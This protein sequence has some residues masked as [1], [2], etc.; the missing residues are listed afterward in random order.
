[1]ATGQEKGIGGRNQEFVLSASPRIAGD[2]KIV[3]GS[4][5]SDGT[6][7]PTDIAGG[8]VDGTSLES[9][10]EA[11]FNINEELRH[12]NSSP[13]L[14]AISDAV[15][16]GNTGTNLRDLRIIYMSVNDLPLHILN[17]FLLHIETATLMASAK[18]SGFAFPCHAISK[19]V[20]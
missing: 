19:A 4:V 6:D 11:G 13:V 3:I 18:L 17:I 9:I 14:Q 20:P 5:D 2:K 15:I 8:I 16:M 10:T 7:G 12:H 1:M